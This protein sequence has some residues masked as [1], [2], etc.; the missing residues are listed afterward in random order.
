[1]YLG[2]V[3]IN[4]VVS[5]EF[6]FENISDKKAMLSYEPITNLVNATFPVKEIYP[7]EKGIV[8]INFYP[9]AEGP[10]NEKLYV[11]VNGSENIELAIYGN[12]SS[13]SKAYKSMGENNKLFGDKDI[14][15]IIVDAQNLK[16][17][18]N[19]KIFIR[20]IIN[21][22]CYIGISDHYGVLINRIPEGKYKIQALV[23]NYKSES[24]DIRLDPD[25]NIAL[26]L[27][28]RPDSKD[29]FIAK[30]SPKK[31]EPIQPKKIADSIIQEPQ[32]AEIAI[33]EVKIAE[34]TKVD[35]TRK[36]L[37]IILLIDVSKSMEKPNRIGILKKSIINMIN[38][39]EANDELAILTFND[40]VTSLMERK[41]IDDKKSVVQLI[42][43][44]LPSGTTDG[45]LG[46]DKA[47]EILQK[48]YMKDAINM[49]ILASDGK[50]SNNSYDDKNMF[51]KIELMNEQG[52]LT[53]VV[54]F[55][56]SSYD[57]S[58][59]SKMAN[60]GGG[61]YINM[62]VDVENME[63]ILLDEIYS[64]LLKLKR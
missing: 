61:I 42:N 28:E 43:S 22:K 25:R 30:E 63:S 54:G 20:N 13:I 3:D 9:D 58:K 41:K 21:Q 44:I 38:N 35:G 1:M 8:K 27:L 7:K 48:N 56:T 46:I 6:N 17:I 59:L 11:K 15:F 18:P 19:A 45:V 47:F 24:L 4:N 52:I 26:I 29:S 62:N 16:G 64:T 57:Q 40:Q 36:P 14:S 31:G 50:I 60:L 49:V 10:F 32:P 51:E 33:E 5:V 2:E 34:K 23:D 55:G 39:Y 37:N 12:V 53:S